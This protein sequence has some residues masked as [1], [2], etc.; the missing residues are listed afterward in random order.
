MESYVHNG[1][2]RTKSSI[3]NGAIFTSVKSYLENILN[4]FELPLGCSFFHNLPFCE[5]ANKCENFGIKSLLLI[6]NF[7]FKIRNYAM[8]WHHQ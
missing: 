6:E 1:T 4:Q 8:E 5:K 2:F 7:F 3:Y